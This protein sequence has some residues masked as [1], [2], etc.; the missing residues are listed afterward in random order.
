MTDKNSSPRLSGGKHCSIIGIFANLFLFLIKLTASIVSGSLSAIADAFNNLTDASSSI[1][2]FLGFR[3]AEKSA[4]DE[5]PYGHARA[6]YLSALIVAMFI[7]LIGFELIKTAVKEIL[8]P[9]RI[10]VTP[11]VFVIL[12]VS[13]IIKIVMAVYNYHVGKR[14]SSKTLIATAADSRNDAIITTGIILGYIITHFTNLSLDGYI[15]LFISLF[16]FIS[17]ISLIK[18]TMDPL[19]GKAPDKELVGYIQ[20]KIL[21]YPH[22]L[23]THDLIVHD[24]GVERRFASVHVEM[25]AEMDVIESHD[26]IDRMEDDF[27][28]EDNIHM[29]VHFDPIVTDDNVRSLRRTVSN[30]ASKIHPECTIHDLRVK[31]NCVSFDCVK[32]EGCNIS[33]E[34]LIAAFDVAIRLTNPDYS[35]Q[36]TIDT[37]FSPII[38]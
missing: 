34:A 14:I 31:E 7:L 23:G 30:I 8:S 11:I 9:S 27:L 16:I 18:S 13:V 5:H 24:Y 36:I 6:E 37:S 25:A 4:D 1:V 12:A 3:F 15:S 38:N 21:S 17:G 26:I 28:T 33:D 19:L 20:Q 35:V 32:P 10:E 22:I 2:S 29:I